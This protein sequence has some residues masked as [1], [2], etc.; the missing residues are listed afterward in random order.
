LRICFSEQR[1][2]NL[3]ESERNCV[4]SCRALHS[5]HLA[6]LATIAMAW[7]SLASANTV[8]IGPSQDTT[9]FQNNVNNSLGGAPG[10]YAGTNSNT[11][12]F[13]PR[14]ALIQFDVAS[15]IPAGSTINSVQLTLTY[16]FFAGPPGAGATLMNIDLHRVTASWGEGTVTGGIGLTGIGQG[17]AAAPGD[18]TWSSRFFG[19]QSWTNPGG[20]FV[21]TISASQLVGSATMDVPF[22]WGSTAQMVADVQGWLDTPSSNHGWILRGPEEAVQTGRIFYSREAT[23]PAFRPTL[24]ITYTPVPEPSAIALAAVAIVLLGACRGRPGRQTR[25]VRRG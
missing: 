19:S 22:T 20:D 11:N 4:M 3:T 15:A 16:G 8:T 10:L 18:A 23:N 21:G 7:P 6:L 13:S 5:L 25:S 14:R 17:F 1:L 24:T 2:F 12:P 9:I